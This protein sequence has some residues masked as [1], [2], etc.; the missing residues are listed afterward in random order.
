MMFRDLQQSRSQSLVPF[1]QRSKKES[2]GSNHSEITKEIT[3]FCP[4]GFTQSASMAH[5]WNG[6]S[7]SSRFLPQARR[8]VG[9]G[10]ENGRA[11]ARNLGHARVVEKAR[12][13]KVKTEG[14]SHNSLQLWN[15]TEKTDLNTRLHSYSSAMSQIF[16]DIPF[17]WPGFR[18]VIVAFFFSS[19]TMQIKL[20]SNNMATMWEQH[21]QLSLDGLSPETFRV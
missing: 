12:L 9:S 20:C 2:S 21:H 11:M 14:E 8:I 15:F 6:C 3:E 7:Q 10:D 1:D 13:R 17:V 18:V 4:S 16:T 5:A 19:K